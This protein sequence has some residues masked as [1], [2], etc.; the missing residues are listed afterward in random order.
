MTRLFFAAILLSSWGFQS[1]DIKFYSQVASIDV[2]QNK[3]VQ[4]ELKV[5]SQQREKLNVAATEFNADVQSLQSQVREG[6]ITNSEF[7][8]KVTQSQAGLKSKVLSLLGNDQITRLGQITLQYASFGA[9][10]S[11]PVIQK[12]GMTQAQKDQLKEAWTTLGKNVAEA[13]RSIRS[14]IVQKYQAL[15]PKSQQEKDKVKADFEAEM[16]KANEAVQPKLRTLKKDFE[17]IVDKLLTS[18]Q[19]T[20]WKSLL[21]PE[22][23]F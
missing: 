19:K 11:E 14:P 3:A 9:L 18:G 12:L 6:K 21:G 16:A 4:S 5:T 8:T 13:E 7:G 10:L 22:F 20:L 23:K 17:A 2:L 1:G 15:D